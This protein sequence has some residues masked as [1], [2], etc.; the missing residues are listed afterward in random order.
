MLSLALPG[1]S[2]AHRLPAGVKL[3][4]LALVMVGALRLTSVPA[5]A[6]ALGAMAGLYA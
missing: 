3:G 5:V 2:W 1:T 6:L 4:A